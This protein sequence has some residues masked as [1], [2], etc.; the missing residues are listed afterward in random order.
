MRSFGNMDKDEDGC[1]HVLTNVEWRQE[2]DH[3]CG[4]IPRDNEVDGDGT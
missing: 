2:P 1:I 4:S 3:C